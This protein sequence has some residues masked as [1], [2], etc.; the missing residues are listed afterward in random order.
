MTLLL[1]FMCMQLISFF[2]INMSVC[3]EN[4]QMR[5]LGFKKKVDISVHK[6]YHL[7]VKKRHQINKCA[8]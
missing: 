1:T 2:S 5:N 8:K 4:L 3:F 7:V 6:H